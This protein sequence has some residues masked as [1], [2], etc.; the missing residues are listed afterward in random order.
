[1][2]R[3]KQQFKLLRS[4]APDASQKA[5]FR[6]IL[7]SRVML[8]S[9]ALPARSIFAHIGQSMRAAHA[10][11]LAVIIALTASGSGVSFA[12]QNAIPGETL[13]PVKLATERARIAVTPGKKTKA[14]LHLGFASRRLNEIEQLIEQNGDAQAAISETLTRYENELD[15]SETFSMQ[16]PLLAQALAPLVGET[17]ES[18]KQTLKRV[19]QKAHT[20]SFDGDLDDDFDDAYE[21]AE[22]KDDAVLYAALAATSTPPTV[23]S[24]VI[25]EKSRKKWESI[26]YEMKKMEAARVAP[27]VPESTIA[28]GTA[29]ALT[30]AQ[31]R[32]D[33][34][35]ARWENGEYREALKHSIEAREFVKEAEK[36]EKERRKENEREKNNQREEDR[37]KD[38]DERDN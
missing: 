8:E 32:I 21:H 6:R 14:E 4:I 10:L 27:A 12:A 26:E 31:E 37:D 11:A 23:I 28:T 29:A 7:Q 17:T 9:R 1:M 16:D 19:A 30:T 35:K 36:I 20:R 33:E 5:N 18:H 34:A 13:Y 15:E 22:S 3:I 38:E 2:N 24:L 25:K